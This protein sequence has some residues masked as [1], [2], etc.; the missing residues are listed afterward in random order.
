MSKSRNRPPRLETRIGPQRAT[1]PPTLQ[2]ELVRSRVTGP[3]VTPGA[4]EVRRL[5]ERA[6]EREPGVRLDDAWADVEAVFGAT[7]AAPHIDPDL[8][9]EAARRAVRKIVDVAS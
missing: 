7:L 5:V 4:S 8:T 6:A 9:I 2:E 3:G 1:P